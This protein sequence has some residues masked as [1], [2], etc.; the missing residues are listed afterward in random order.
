MHPFSKQRSISTTDFNV[1]DVA[2]NFSWE[3]SYNFGESWGG[4]ATENTHFA[5]CLLRKFMTP[6]NAKIKRWICY[7][8]SNIKDTKI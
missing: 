8:K 3:F 4:E 6:I 1:E 2:E 5:W 7:F